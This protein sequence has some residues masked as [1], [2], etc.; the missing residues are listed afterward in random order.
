MKPK[1]E[2]R[3]LW[4]G[5]RQDDMVEGVGLLVFKV[6]CHDN[7][8]VVLKNCR[9]VLGIVLQQYET[10]WLSEEEWRN[11]LPGWFIKTCA[12]ERT[13]EEEEEYL[14]RW[15]ALSNE[16]RQRLAEEEKWSVMD[17]ISWFEPSDD[18][19]NE[20]TW[21]WWDAFIKEPNLLVIVIEVVDIPFPLG[22]LI[23]LLRASGALKV[24]EVE[25]DYMVSS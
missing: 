21:F 16:E 8:D 20:R 7:A 11:K 23:W 22:S 17:W 6:H 19:F 4:S 1:E 15:R 14:L 24:E 10:I 25:K 3:H 13:L 2:L 5:A 18:L 9:E 12:P